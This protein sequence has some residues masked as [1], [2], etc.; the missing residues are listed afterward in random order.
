MSLFEWLKN[1]LSQSPDDMLLELVNATGAAMGSLTRSAFHIEQ[2]AQGINGSLTPGRVNQGVMF[3]YGIMLGLVALKFCWKGYKVWVLWRDGDS[4]SSPWEMLMHT[5]YAVVVA[6]AFPV[7]YNIVVS[8]STSLVTNL[9]AVMGGV[10]ANNLI[11]MLPDLIVRGWTSGSYLL[12]TTLLAVYVIVFL[13]VAVQAMLRGAEMLIYR[14]GFPLAT[15]GLVDSD[16]GVFKG[17]VQLFFRM[18]VTILVQDILVRLSLSSTANLNVP[19]VLFGI[20][21]LIGAFKA[22][23]T[24]AGLFG[25]AGGGGMGG[26]VSSAV[27]AARIF[28]TKG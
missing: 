25:A 7:I 14:L 6:V 9:I 16:G 12:I 19:G 17:Y 8:L 13:V 11:L 18:L 15:V 1:F 10:S 26:V 22:P 2:V 20:V 21:L 5:G 24:F 4:E 3:M 27:M 23:K 28:I